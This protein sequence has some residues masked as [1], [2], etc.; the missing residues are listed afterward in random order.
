M[1]IDVILSKKVKN[2]TLEEKRFVFIIGQIEMLADRCSIK[3]LDEIIT[4][5]SSKIRK[6]F[7][8]TE[9]QT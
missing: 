9:I 4:F 7:P 2:M 5:L 6:H 3:D 8:L 1:N